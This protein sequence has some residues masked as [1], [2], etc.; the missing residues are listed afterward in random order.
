[1]ETGELSCE[2]RAARSKGV[3]H[4]LRRA[5]RIPGVLYGPKTTATAV[6]VELLVAEAAR[7]RHILEMNPRFLKARQM[8]RPELSGPIA[9]KNVALIPLAA[10][11]PASRGT[12][13]R[14]PS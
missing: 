11:I 8:A 10:N 1:M 7:V 5:G 9:T 13:S 14:N 2:A 3:L 12:P 4:Q 6:S